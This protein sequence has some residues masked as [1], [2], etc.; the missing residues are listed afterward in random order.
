MAK[1][2]QRAWRNRL[3]PALNRIPGLEYE[4][5]ELSTGASGMPDLMVSFHGTVFIENKWSSVVDGYLDLTGWAKVQRNW[6]KRHS[7][8]GTKVLLFIATETENYLI[9]TEGSYRRERISASD[10]NILCWWSVGER[11]PLREL[12][13]VFESLGGH[14]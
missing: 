9:D 12:R 5:I 11:A 7:K 4:R 14:A 10:W 3:K 13:R 6:A 2:E 1:P 8:A